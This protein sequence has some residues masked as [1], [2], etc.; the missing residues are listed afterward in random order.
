M[1]RMLSTC[2][3][4][5]WN[6]RLREYRP[7]SQRPIPYRTVTTRTDTIICWKTSFA[8]YAAPCQRS[9]VMKRPIGNQPR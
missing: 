7:I 4:R 9:A 6:T 8:L 3:A 2:P 1:A 5:I